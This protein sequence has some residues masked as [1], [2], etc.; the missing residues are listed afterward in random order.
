MVMFTFLNTCIVPC[1]LSFPYFSI[2]WTFFPKPVD[3]CNF[4]LD[5]TIVHNCTIHIQ[6]GIDAAEWIK[7][8]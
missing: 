6:E 7:E 1:N 3:E 8:M 5:T 2:L 4:M